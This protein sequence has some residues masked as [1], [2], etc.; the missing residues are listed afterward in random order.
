MDA[1]QKVV[2]TSAPPGIGAEFVKAF[3]KLDYRVVAT[4]RSIEPSKDPNILTVTDDITDCETGRR[5][6]RVNQAIEDDTRT[7]V[8]SGRQLQ[9]AF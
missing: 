1:L 3:R 7:E 5:V 8:P 9:P 6:I 2:V 4:A